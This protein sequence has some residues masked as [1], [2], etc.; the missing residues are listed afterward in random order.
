MS[1][2][3]LTLVIPTIDAMKVTYDTTYIRSRMPQPGL[4]ELTTF[5]SD[6]W[7]EGD[8]GEAL[9]AAR[10]QCVGPW[11]LSVEKVRLVRKVRID[12]LS[13]PTHARHTADPFTIL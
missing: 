3:L 12:A 4:V 13:G 6:Y 5:E 7:D 10:L 11:S 9:I 8:G 1:D 2:T